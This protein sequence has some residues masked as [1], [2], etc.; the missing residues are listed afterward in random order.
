MTIVKAYEGEEVTDELRD[1]ITKIDGSPDRELLDDFIAD[2]ASV[3]IKR[4]S[5]TGPLTGFLIVTIQTGPRAPT[6]FISIMKPEGDKMLLDKAHELYKNANV[7]LNI[8]GATAYINWIK[9][10]RDAGITTA[11]LGQKFTENIA[12]KIGN[13]LAGGKRRKTRGRRATRRPR[14]RKT[15]VRG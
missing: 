8:D 4:D 1:Q 10:K 2:A 5:E 12:S 3:I 15:R 6:Y 14:T 7:I 13:F 9:A 11:T